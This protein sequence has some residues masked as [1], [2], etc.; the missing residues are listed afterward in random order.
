M[1]DYCIS[2][3]LFL[4]RGLGDPEVTCNPNLQDK[5][6][7]WYVEENDHPRCEFA[8]CTLAEA[9]RMICVHVALNSGER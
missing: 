3:D 9:S 2:I 5:N 7:V 1:I 6:A 4:N 8:F